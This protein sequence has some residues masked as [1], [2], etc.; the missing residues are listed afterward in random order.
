MR[1]LKILSAVLLIVV[2]L[3]GVGVAM[4]WAP[5]RS[6]ESIT[7]RWAPPPS[8]IVELESM[9]VHVRDEGPPGNAVPLVLLYGTSASRHTWD[10]W[11]TAL[12]GQH[13][14]VRLD[15][16]GCGLTGPMPDND[17][18]HKRCVRFVGEFLDA[19]GVRKCVLV[20][21]SF[22]G[23]V[24]WETAVALPQRVVKLVLVDVAGYPTQATSIPIGF[25]LAMN[26]MLVPFMRKLL[27]RRVVESSVHNV[28]SDP[29]KV[30]TELVDRYYELALRTGNRQA[31]V[32]RFCQSP[33][34]EDVALIA[35]IR[36]PTLIL[37]GQ[38]DRL[39]PVALGRRFAKDITGS[40]LVMLEGLARV[41]QE[42]DPVR[43]V[44]E[45][46]RFLADK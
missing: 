43:S 13:R 25:K 4:S 18:S 20:G 46:D 11:V 5:D 45:F 6:V 37:W 23:E 1:P 16:P 10:G 15:L 17:Y 21:N 14:L 7:P 32:E 29:D 42:E 19:M 31:L 22:G 34:G 44:A 3:L 36:Q 39:I 30:T 33:G 38:N 35:R 40:H 28:Y 24:A 41:P 2:M 27:P 8:R 26:P 12:K 9:H